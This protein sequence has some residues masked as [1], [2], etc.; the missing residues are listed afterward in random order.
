MKDKFPFLPENL[1]TK[2]LKCKEPLIEYSHP[3]P[4]P[5]TPAQHPQVNQ[6]THHST[7]IITWNASSLNTALPNLHQLI[8]NTPNNPTIITIQET[9]LTATKSTKY[10]QNLFPQYKLIFNNTHALTRCIQQRIPYTPAR[11]GLLT[12]IN[13]TYA[14]PSNIT[15]PPNNRNKEP[16]PTTM[17]NNTHLHANTRRRYKIYTNI[18]TKHNTTNH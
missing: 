4:L 13:N 9:K 5:N 2:S 11:G 15:I 18:T 10:I 17:A 1:L 7:H 8:S 14:Y 16:T 3:P 12:L 6:T